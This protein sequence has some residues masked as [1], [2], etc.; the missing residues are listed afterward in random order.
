[1]IQTLN[2]KSFA[3]QACAQPLCYQSS[4]FFKF[5]SWSFLA[6]DFAIGRRRR[7]RWRHFRQQKNWR[8]NVETSRVVLPSTHLESRLL[9]TA[10]AVPDKVGLRRTKDAHYRPRGNAIEHY[11]GRIIHLNKLL[12]VKWCCW[13]TRALKWDK[14]D[15]VV[16]ICYL[17]N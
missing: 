7:R 1:M 5:F 15:K 16:L 11:T 3:P 14:H 4:I 17:N 10:Q 12:F 8:W 6:E 2:L 13:T 9:D